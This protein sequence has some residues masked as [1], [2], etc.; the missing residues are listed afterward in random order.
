M[1]LYCL[2]LPRSFCRVIDISEYIFTLV[3]SLHFLLVHL[4]SLTGWVVWWLTLSIYR[5]HCTSSQEEY[6]L[7][8]FYNLQCCSML[9]FPIVFTLFCPIYKK[10]YIAVLLFILFRMC[11]C[12]CA[13]L[14]E[15]SF[16]MSYNC[17][18]QLLLR[19]YVLLLVQYTTYE[20]S[21]YM[22]YFLVFDFSLI[23]SRIKAIMTFDFLS[24]VVVITKNWQIFVISF[25]LEMQRELIKKKYF[26]GFNGKSTTMSLFLSF[27][28]YKNSFCCLYI[29]YHP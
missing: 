21:T 19:Q 7:L 11:A 8:L 1:T 13:W 5:P 20:A 29:L 17:Y 12:I 22:Y 3:K 23:S 18:F 16:Y 25:S 15:S 10:F 26:K 27:L 9:V 14:C 4:Y 28:F 2:V 6:C 24:G